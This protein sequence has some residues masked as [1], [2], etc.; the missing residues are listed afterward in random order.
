MSY[1][2]RVPRNFKLLDEL[3]KGERGYNEG[4]HAGW[5]SLGLDGDDIYLSD[6][7]ATVI[8][9][10]GTQIGERIYTV[11]V[12]CGE[13]YPNVPPSVTFITRINMAHI[14]GNGVVTRACPAIS[15]WTPSKTIFD[16]LCSLREL[17]KAAAPL[18]QPPLESTY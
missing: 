1:V 8:G 12:H 2:Y 3:E 15:N 4:E 14:D 18:P 11:K 5:I 17:M 10:Q 7:L 9:P 13:N 6:W 16:V